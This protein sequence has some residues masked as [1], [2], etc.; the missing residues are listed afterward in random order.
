VGCLCNNA[1]LKDDAVTGQPTEGALLVLATKANIADPRNIHRRMEELP[2][3][4]DTKI[5]SVTCTP[6]HVKDNVDLDHHG[7]PICVFVKGSPD[8]IIQ[9]SLYYRGPAMI[10]KNLHSA[11]SDGPILPLNEA[12]REALMLEAQNMGQNGLRVLALAEGSS[13]DRLILLGLVGLV[14]PPRPGVDAAIETIFAAG[15]NVIMIT[16]DAKETACTIAGRLGLFQ[17]HNT[18][19]SGFELDHMD[20]DTLSREIR[21]TTVFYRTTPKH[22]CKI[23]KALQKHG[24]VVAMTGD[25]V[26]DAVA[27]KSAD[28]GVAM[29]QGGTDVCKEAAD[30]VLVNNDFA[31]ILAAME[32][33]KAIFHNIRNFVRFQLSTS[34]SAL[35]L[36]A[37]STILKMPSPLN[38]MQILYINILMD[39]PPAQSLGLEPPDK[40]VIR[41]PPRRVR[42][43]ILNVRVFVS[44]LLSSAVIVSGTFWVFYNEMSADGQVTPR[45]TTMSFTCFVL[46]DIFNALSCRSSTRSVFSIGLFTNRI[47]IITVLISLLG[48]LLVIY[49]PPLQSI[50]QTE[51]ISA[52]D[53]LQLVLISSTVFI[54]NEIQKFLIYSPKTRHLRT[55]FLG[56]S[57]TSHNPILKLVSQ[58]IPKQR[59]QKNRYRSDFSV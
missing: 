52:L 50:F 28:V 21:D 17:A 32:E 19:M 36:I 24:L 15:V 53:L 43:S 42:E 37:L 8:S 38:P 1:V 49:A 31:C 11:L 54:V 41:Q 58:F 12:I 48:Q 56:R 25:G 33:G 7:H 57:T 30:I 44:I 14:D 51:R 34:I 35:C 40:E 23:V 16:G 20:V 39:G 18:A 4:S 10:H 22:K 26:N 46:F 5:M 45:D 2:F 6:R 27:V 13:I 47:F 59:F 29:G 55:S 9:R 3:S